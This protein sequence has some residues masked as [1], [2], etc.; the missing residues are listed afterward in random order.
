VSADAVPGEREPQEQTR[1]ANVGGDLARGSKFL[2]AIVA[3]AAGAAVTLFQVHDRLWPPVKVYGGEVMS[4]DVVQVGTSFQRYV[5]D[6]RYLFPDWKKTIDK[7]RSI[8][9]TRGAVVD[10]VFKMQGLRGRQFIVR[11]TVYRTPFTP[12]VGPAVALGTAT[13]H[14]QD[15][16]QGGWEQWVE[17]PTRQNAADA[18]VSL[19]GRYFVRFDL[20]DDHGLLIGPGRAT[21]TFGWNGEAGSR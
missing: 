9:T 16:D 10:V 12:V 11:Y 5:S 7:N 18:G 17:L 20:F 15:G 4:A 3:G 14:V 6:H 21:Q 1:I 8:D 13:S 19:E 2:I